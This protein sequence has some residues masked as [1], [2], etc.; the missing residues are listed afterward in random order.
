MTQPNLRIIPKKD[1]KKK[2]SPREK[3]YWGLVTPLAGVSL[4]YQT[5]MSIRDPVQPTRFYYE[6]RGSQVAEYGGKE[7]KL[8]A[9]PLALFYKPGVKAPEEFE[10]ALQTRDGQF[11]KA[12]AGYLDSSNAE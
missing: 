1:T 9:K 2:M 3:L 10:V 11:L 12:T 7:I 8:T 6:P 5:G 4:I